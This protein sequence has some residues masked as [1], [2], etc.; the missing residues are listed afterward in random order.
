[1]FAVDESSQ[2]TSESKLFVRSNA[3]RDLEVILKATVHDVRRVSMRRPCR[4]TEGVLLSL[5]QILSVVARYL[6]S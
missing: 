6:R 1:M 3:G 2:V 4:V 5:E